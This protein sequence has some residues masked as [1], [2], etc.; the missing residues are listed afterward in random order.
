VVWKKKKKEGPEG[1][2]LVLPAN[3]GIALSPRLA[4]IFTP[5]YILPGL[6]HT[7]PAAKT[8]FL[9]LPCLQKVFRSSFSVLHTRPFAP[10]SAPRR[11]TSQ[12]FCL[13]CKGLA[14]RQLAFMPAVKRSAKF[15]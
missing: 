2:I 11:T 8:H 3:L 12:L 15:H 14:A 7:C 13:D 4:G 6:S 5:I 10:I 9:L 1:N